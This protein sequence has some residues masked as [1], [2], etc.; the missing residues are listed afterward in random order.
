MQTE[1]NYSIN[2]DNI[3]SGMRRKLLAP[4]RR[5][6][7]NRDD[8]QKAGSR[9]GGKPEAVEREGTKKKKK[10]DYAFTIEQ[11]RTETHFSRKRP[12]SL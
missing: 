10:V 5:R 12:Y 8:E 7:Q 2:D 1:K 11:Q 4:P 9:G 3:F 6:L